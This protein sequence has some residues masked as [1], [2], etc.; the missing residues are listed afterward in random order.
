MMGPPLKLTVA[1][2]N[3]IVRLV[4]QGNYRITAARAAGIHPATLVRWEAIGT[5]EIERREAGEEP[6]RNLDPHVDLCE[7]L[8]RAEADC[9]AWLVR[10]WKDAAPADWRAAERLLAVRHPERFR[11]SREVEA[12]SHTDGDGVTRIKVTFRGGAEE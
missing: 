3:A 7:R 11:Q 4:R 5:A 1:R 10:K 8:T 2:R 12:E 6:D 9:E